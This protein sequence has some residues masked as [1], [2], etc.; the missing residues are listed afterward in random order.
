MIKHLRFDGKIRQN[1]HRL[2]G[3]L[4]LIQLGFKAVPKRGLLSLNND[5]V[6]AVKGALSLYMSVLTE[7][8]VR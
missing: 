2:L 3:A 6:V 5:E 4:K 8:M 1:N 7:K